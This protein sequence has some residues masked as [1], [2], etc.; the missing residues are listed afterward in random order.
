MKTEIVTFNVGGTR[1]EVSRSLLD[2][3]PNT[4]LAKSAS[5]Q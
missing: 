4:M 3:H 1:Y 2:L 5:E